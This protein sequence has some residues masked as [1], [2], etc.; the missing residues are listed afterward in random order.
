MNFRNR[1][2]KSPHSI[3]TLCSFRRY[4]YNKAE[5]KLVELMN[6]QTFFTEV[7]SVVFSNTEY[8]SGKQKPRSLF[9]FILHYFAK[10]LF[11]K[12]TSLVH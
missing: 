5:G 10:E 7:I 4:N 9:Q 8:I 12:K 11:Q 1:N 2:S 6:E 3:I